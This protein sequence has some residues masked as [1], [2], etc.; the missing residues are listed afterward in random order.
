MKVPKQ[1]LNKALFLGHEHKFIIINFIINIR[2]LPYGTW[3]CDTLPEQKYEDLFKIISKNLNAVRFFMNYIYK[4]DKDW[5][6]M[7][8][9]LWHNCCSL[10]RLKM[11]NWASSIKICFQ[12]RQAMNIYKWFIFRVW[13]IDA[14]SCLVELLLATLMLW[15]CTT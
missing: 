7:M 11:L 15:W 5:L 1:L 12:M 3:W 9:P 4:K 6:T 13:V 2:Q 8:R 10:F 14:M